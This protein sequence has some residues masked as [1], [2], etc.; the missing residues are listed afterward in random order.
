LLLS[1]LNYIN[2]N[3]AHPEGG[4]LWEEIDHQFTK[5]TVHI[6]A[7]VVKEHYGIW[8]WSRPGP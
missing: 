5:S 3:L 4:P 7:Q 6:T 8:A 2:T 1:H